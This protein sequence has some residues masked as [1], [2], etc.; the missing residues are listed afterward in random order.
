MRYLAPVLLA[1]ATAGVPA[2]AVAQTAPVASQSARALELS[3]NNG[4][5]TLVAR[6]VTVPEI[7]AEWA[8]KGGSKIVNGE[9]VASGLVAFEFHDVPESRVLQSVLRSAAGFIAAPRRPGGPTGDSAIEQVM[10]LATSRPSASSSAVTMP[11]S[12]VVY[13]EPPPQQPLQ[14]SPDDDIPPVSGFGAPRAPGVAPVPSDRP[15]VGVATSPTPG[16]V[17]A[18]TKPGTPVPPGTIIK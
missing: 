13:N 2:Q 8:R 4:L 14:G 7:M 9:K 5:V 16:V 3:F 17:I 1:L 15:T 10:I 18:P 11:T 6:G 12:P